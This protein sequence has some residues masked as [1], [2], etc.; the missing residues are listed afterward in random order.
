MKKRNK[1]IFS[2]GLSGLTVLSMF[3]HPVGI[4]AQENA[5]IPDEDV[6]ADTS[7]AAE[8]EEAGSVTNE[9]VSEETTD[10]VVEPSVP[11]NNNIGVE[12]DSVETNLNEADV[13]SA[14]VDTDVI[15]MNVSTKEI[16]SSIAY[17]LSSDKNA[18]PSTDKNPGQFK[19]SLAVKSQEVVKVNLPE[20]MLLVNYDTPQGMKVKRSDNKNTTTLVYTNVQEN[21][22]VV[23]F[24][25]SYYLGVYLWGNPSGGNIQFAPGIT[26]LPVTVSTDTKELKGIIQVNNPEPMNFVADTFNNA[27]PT[28]GYTAD[29]KSIYTFRL[30]IVHDPAFYDPA[31]GSMVAN[32][33]IM[34]GVIHVPKGFVL[35]GAKMSTWEGSLR[36]VSEDSDFVPGIPEGVSQPDGAGGDI[37]IS[38]VVGAGYSTLP[39]SHHYF[40]GYFEKGTPDGE[41]QFTPELKLSINLVGGGQSTV[42]IKNRKISTIRLGEA[43]PGIMQAAYGYVLEGYDKGNLDVDHAGFYSRSISQENGITGFLTGKDNDARVNATQP[44]IA[45]NFIDEATNQTNTLRTYKL[46]LPKN[47]CGNLT[48][49]KISTAPRSYL[50]SV[51]NENN[52][53]PFTITL[54]TGNTFEVSSLN[55]E[56]DRINQALQAGAHIV[57]VEGEANILAGNNIIATLLNAVIEDGTYQNGDSVPIQLHVHS[58]TSN[59][60]MDAIGHLKYFDQSAVASTQFSIKNS[61]GFRIEGVYTQ[62]Q[63]IRTYG[64]SILN[65]EVSFPKDID[66]KLVIPDAVMKGKKITVRLPI[67]TVSSTGHQMIDI[68]TSQ[69]KDY[70]WTYQGKKYYPEITDLGTDE[71]TGE[72]LMKFDF[73]MYTVEVPGDINPGAAFFYPDQ[74]RY[75]VNDLAPAMTGKVTSWSVKIE[76]TNNDEN[77]PRYGGMTYYSYPNT[78]WTITAP[79]MISFKNGISGKKTGNTYYT[80]NSGKAGFDRGT[81]SNK[82]DDINEG[83]LRLAINNGTKDA[84]LNAQAV[85]VLPSD[86]EFSLKLTGPGQV[87]G[88]STIYYSEKRY[89]LPETNSNKKVDLSTSDWMQSDQVKDWSKIQ[90]VALSANELEAESSMVGYLPI[91]VENIESTEIGKTGVVPTYSYAQNKTRVGNLSNRTNLEAIVYGT[92]EIH[93]YYKETTDGA[94]S[95]GKDLASPEVITG[96]NTDGSISKYE[97]YGT[98]PKTIEDY[99]YV[100]IEK[101]ESTGI[102][103]DQAQDV[104]YLYQKESR[105]I[106]I[107]YIDVTGQEIKDKWNP[108]DGTEREDLKQVLTGSLSTE[109]E[110]QLNVPAGYSAIQVPD[111]ARQGTYTKNEDLYV[112]IAADTQKVVYS[113]IDDTDKKILEENVEFDSG[114]S[115]TSLHKTQQDLQDLAKTY[116]DKGYEIVEV[117]NLPKKFDQDTTKDQTVEIHVRHVYV[118]ITS[119]DKKVPGETIDGS[120][121]VWPQEADP[122]DLTKTITRTIEYIDNYTGKEIADPV[123]QE[124]VFQREVIIDKVSGNVVGYQK[125]E[126]TIQDGEQA[127][128]SDD[129]TWKEITSP[130]LSDKGYEAPSISTVEEKEVTPDMESTTTR[131]EYERSMQKVVYSVIDDT[132]KKILEEN[133]EFDSGASN[134]SLHKTQQDLHDLAKTYEDKGYEIVEVGNLPDK[135]DQNTAKDQT[136][137]IHVRH[138]YVTITSKDKKVPGETIDGSNAVWPQE[139]DPSDLT[140][141]ITRTIEY[142]DNYT[143]KEIA[144]PVMQEVVFQREVIIDKVSGDVVGYQKGEKTIQDGEQAWHSDDA[145]WK[146][147]TSPDLSEKGYCIPNISSVEAKTVLPSFEAQAIQVPSCWAPP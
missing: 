87:D 22:A 49:I 136:I 47:W 45:V 86:K 6:P 85:A 58:A 30:E 50:S 92:P 125:G 138:A 102:L 31:M 11:V 122:S 68:D 134:T 46:I 74:M 36:N 42:D 143:G 14:P 57:S 113:V 99:T 4:H 20:G 64:W 133:V 80:Q 91:H 5:E 120:N 34:N 94:L 83:T 69:L 53:G 75:K 112:Y 96:K 121:V 130:D 129:T 59:T 131:V 48:D 38:N 145:T 110:N 104:V 44:Y 66:N 37:I 140:K 12:N 105:N 73:S 147:I 126:E 2:S 27:E 89:D 132:D 40:Y 117:G 114:A 28:N 107:H 17:T 124:V 67:M 52:N 70:G 60:D 1:K 135:F 51:G 103:N 3:V 79:S 10:S 62:G 7:L 100:G 13:S 78:N 77:H 61:P 15:D 56:D 18:Y 144:D 65:K 76:D 146:E 95:N 115:D 25:I 35:K 98:S 119:K 71:E 111:E 24:N 139:V 108:E 128:H 90:S 9:N 55:Q 97:P 33:P 32:S 106:T 41:S 109:Y 118:T 19:V 81:R 26:E 21:D 54:D 23:S 72:H 82:E 43:N 123:Q 93:V 141:T 142:I 127:W 88:K 16:D 29:G 137:E 39:V 101:G 116:E 84:F 8:P 63:E